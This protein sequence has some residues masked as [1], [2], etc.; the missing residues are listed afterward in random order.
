MLAL[1]LGRQLMARRLSENYRLSVVLAVI[2]IVEFV[3]F[4]KGHPGDDGGITVAVVGSL[5]LA[6]AFGAARR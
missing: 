5:V 3:D 4:L 1:V 6:A 2:G